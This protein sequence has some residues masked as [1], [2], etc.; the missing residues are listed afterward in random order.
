MCVWLCA[1][2]CVCVCARARACVHACALIFR[3]PTKAKNQS[4]IEEMPAMLEAFCLPFSM[5]ILQL[6]LS[7]FAARKSVAL[8]L[9]FL[10]VD[11]RRRFVKVG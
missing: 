3:I 7:L 2:V 4:Q 10:I 1:C 6:R 11:A 5:E 9:A 8:L